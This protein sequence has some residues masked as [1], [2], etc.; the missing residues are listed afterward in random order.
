[1]TTTTM[2][3]FAA[4]YFVPEVHYTTKAVVERPLDSVW[5]DFN[6]IDLIDRWIPEI[7]KVEVIN[8]EPGIQGNRYRMT[9]VNG[10]K[11]TVL[12]ET[13]A[14]F[15]EFERVTLHIDAGDMIK[16]DSY[17]FSYDNA[18]TLI[19]GSHT[20]R[21]RTYI[22]RCIYAFFKSMFQKIDQTYL[23]QF[24]DWSQTR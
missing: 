22:H 2:V 12:T 9:A 15:V 14:E 13:V 7:E 24:A 6:N 21:G 18:Q 20:C 8:Q 11:T 19:Q 4:G 1:M 16:T 23:H 5:L 10:G 17:S 3:F